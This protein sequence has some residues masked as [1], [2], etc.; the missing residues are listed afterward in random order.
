M[1]RI[2]LTEVEDRSFEAIPSGRYRLKLDDFEMREVKREDGKVPKGTPMINWEFLVV[3]DAKTGDDKYSG[4][5]VWM[6]TLLIQQSLF[7]L[8]GLLKATGKYTEEEL[9]GELDFDPED[10]MDCEVIGVVSQREYNGDTVN[11]IKRVLPLSE[12]DIEET[13]LLP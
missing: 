9:A 6:N 1:V 12:K 13:S 8:K 5:K 11:D 4:R 3:C 2:N 7:N 10:V